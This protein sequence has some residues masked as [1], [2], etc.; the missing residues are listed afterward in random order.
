MC[1]AGAIDLYKQHIFVFAFRSGQQTLKGIL[2]IDD[3]ILVL[4]RKIF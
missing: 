1:S 4:K 2:E 3:E